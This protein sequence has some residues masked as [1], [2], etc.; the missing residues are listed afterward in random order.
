MD[1]NR[2]WTSL[3]THVAWPRWAHFVIG[4]WLIISAFAWPHA[5]GARAN[6]W[7]LGVLIAIASLWALHTPGAR[8]LNTLFA[9]WLFFATLVL[10]HVSGA[11]VWHNLI[12]AVAVFVL[13]LI[14]SPPPRP[15]AGAHDPLH[16]SC[17]PTPDR[18]TIAARPARRWC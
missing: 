18:S 6:T 4:I 12:A 10:Y 13:S 16:A 1:H 8:F 14:P 9:I 5:A 17:P 3:S 15:G 11:T 7:I 2:N